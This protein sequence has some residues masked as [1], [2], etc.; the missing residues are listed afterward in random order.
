MTPEAE[1]DAMLEVLEQASLVEPYVNDE[2]TE[3]M[4]LT[5]D[6]EHAARQMA[7]PWG[8]SQDVLVAAITKA[9][10]GHHL[11]IVALSV[12]TFRRT[13]LE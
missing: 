3:A 1:L 11:V 6:G 13:M 12:S 9:V 7:M 8:D 2:G 10:E 4:Q 5:A